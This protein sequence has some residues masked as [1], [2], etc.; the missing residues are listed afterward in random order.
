MRGSVGTP[1]VMDRGPR[2]NYKA[3]AKN[4]S[5]FCKKCRTYIQMGQWYSWSGGM[6]VHTYTCP[7]AQRS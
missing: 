4:N 3:K 7:S 6:A 5:L 1:M 2:K